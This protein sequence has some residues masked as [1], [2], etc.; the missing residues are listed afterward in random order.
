MTKLFDLGSILF[1]ASLAWLVWDKTVGTPLSERVFFVVTT[2]IIG[3]ATTVW[4]H[5]AVED[6]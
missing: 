3:V 6:C 1:F 4:M 5:M 2:G